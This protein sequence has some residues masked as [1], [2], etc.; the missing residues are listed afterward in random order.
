[1]EKKSVRDIQSVLVC[2]DPC[3]TERPTGVYHKGIDVLGQFC[4]EVFFSACTH[5]QRS[6]KVMKKILKQ[7]QQEALTIIF[8]W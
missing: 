2:V 4:A 5:T 1:M 3:L 8:V 6:C 7:F